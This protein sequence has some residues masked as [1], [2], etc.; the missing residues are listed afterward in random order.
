MNRVHGLLL[1]PFAVNLHL[2]GSMKELLGGDILMEFRCCAKIMK[3]K[4]MGTLGKSFWVCLTLF[5]TMVGYV[6]SNS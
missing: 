4:R 2:S 1:C 5:R 6:P 3:C